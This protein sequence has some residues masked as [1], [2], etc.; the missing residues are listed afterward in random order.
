MHFRRDALAFRFLRFEQTARKFLLNK[1]PPFQFAFA[2][3]RNR[4]DDG[5][6][7]QRNRQIKPPRPPKRS[8]D[9]NR[10]R[11]A[12]FVPN[13]VAVCRNHAKQIF[14][15]RQMRI[16]RRPPCRSVRPIFVQAFKP[17]FEFDE[18]GVDKTQTRVINFQIRLFGFESDGRLQTDVFRVNLQRFD[19]DGRR[20]RIKRHGFRINHRHA[21]LR[22]KP[23]FAVFCLYSRGRRAAVTFRIE[24]SVAFVIRNRNDFFNTPVG[25]IVQIGFFDAVDAEITANPKIPRVVFDYP[26]RAVVK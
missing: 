11:R 6:H 7:R 3:A 14:A 4:N 21:F 1:L 24:H 25:E 22:R 23:D 13:A 20:M 8:D 26:K 18:F 2:E 5:N 17:I 15:R 9:R 19:D 16:K 10:Q 12:L